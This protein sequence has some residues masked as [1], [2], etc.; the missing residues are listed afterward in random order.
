M[1]LMKKENSVNVKKECGNMQVD[2]YEPAS[3]ENVLRCSRCYAELSSCDKCRI[4]FVSNESFFCAKNRHI[5]C[6]CK[7]N[8]GDD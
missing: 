4:Q 3:A 2:N 6:K 1:V 5:C 8:I 7:N